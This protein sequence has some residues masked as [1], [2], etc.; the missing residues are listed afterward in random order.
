MHTEETAAALAGIRPDPAAEDD[1][2][3][4]HEADEGDAAGMVAGE[5]HADD[6]AAQQH[7]LGCEGIADDEGCDE[8]RRDDGGRDHHHRLHVLPRR[9]QRAR[10]GAGP[11][12]QRRGYEGGIFDDRREDVRRDEAGE[13]SP[14]TPPTDRQ[15]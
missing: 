7:E 8:R 2:D 6:G 4:Q 9:A 14:T 13:Q 11:A 1:E 5:R 12:Q 3:E 15:R 10:Y